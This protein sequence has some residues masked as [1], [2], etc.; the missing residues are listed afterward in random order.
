MHIC[1]SLGFSCLTD[2]ATAFSLP[3][4]LLLFLACLAGKLQAFVF[5]CVTFLG[6]GLITRF[7]ARSHYLACF[8]SLFL[9]SVLGSSLTHLQS[10][11]RSV[12][13]RL[14]V[15]SGYRFAFLLRNS[16]RTKCGDPFSSAG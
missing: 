7:N 15:A 1:G 13:L 2:D 5:L 11:L 12:D 3:I 4:V 8:C 9:C 16:Q 10:F 6:L 14:L